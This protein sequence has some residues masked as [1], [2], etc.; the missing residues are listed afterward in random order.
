MKGSPNIEES[1][2]YGIVPGKSAWKNFLNYQKYLENKGNQEEKEA[3]EQMNTG[4]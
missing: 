2:S 1:L 4:F 3:Y